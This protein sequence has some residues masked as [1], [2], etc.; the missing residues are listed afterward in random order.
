MYRKENNKLIAE[1]MG[2]TKSG[3]MMTVDGSN[4]YNSREE[5]AYIYHGAKYGVDGL[6]YKYSWDWL[7]QWL[8]R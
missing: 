6:R 4:M 8:R 3:T 5:E 1:F 7:C 2:L